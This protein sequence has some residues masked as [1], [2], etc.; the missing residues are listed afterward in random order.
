[1]TD[2]ALSPLR[3]GVV[4]V[5]LQGDRFLVIRRSQ[6]VRAPGRYCFP[7]GGIE[8]NEAEEAALIRELREELSVSV[9][10]L[11][12]LGDSVTSWGVSLSWW[13]TE[14]S[15]AAT[16]MP[17]PQEVES[18][19]WLTSAEMLGLPELLESNRDFLAA[20]TAESILAQW[21]AASG[22]AS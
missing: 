19:H 3:R 7:G 16:L 15:P 2:S 20:H 14:L 4:A 9:R 10:P 1:M 11:C 5:V 22:I 21:H 12:R 6:F 13:Y 18:V 17:D 8:L